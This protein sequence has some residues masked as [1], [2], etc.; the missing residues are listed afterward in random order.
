MKSKKMI[1]EILKR[2][3]QPLKTRQELESFFFF[4]FRKCSLKCT[5]CFWRLK[6][7]EL[8]SL[9]VSQPKLEI[10]GGSRLLHM[11]LLDVNADK[12]LPL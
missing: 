2:H 8:T 1:V 11:K 5:D 12:N 9:F 10:I 3:N 4:F 6:M 7:N